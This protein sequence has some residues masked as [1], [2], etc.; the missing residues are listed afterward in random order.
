[1][2]QKVQIPEKFKNEDILNLDFFLNTDLF[3]N[4]GEELLAQG[5]SIIYCDNEISDKYMI[6]EY[7]D[8]TRHLV[9]LDENG[10][11]IVI[12]ELPK[13]ERKQHKETK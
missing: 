2:K 8:G 13:K 11:N 4:L 12:E 1:M 3:A 6:E 10:N 7:P 5:Q 9:G